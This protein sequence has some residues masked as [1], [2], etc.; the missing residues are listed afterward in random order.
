MK[1]FRWIREVP[2]AK[3]GYE[4]EL[5]DEEK[6]LGDYGK[7]GFR[8]SIGYLIQEGW[9]EEVKDNFW[10]PK[11]GE[12]YFSVYFTGNIIGRR[13]F[14]DE[15]EFQTVV[16]NGNCF[17]TEAEAKNAA[18]MTKELWLSLH[19]PYKNVKYPLIKDIEKKDEKKS[20]CACKEWPQCVH[21]P[22]VLKALWNGY[23]PA[24][25]IIEDVE[26]FKKC[27]Y[28]WCHL[29]PNHLHI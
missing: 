4:F 19:E 27:G 16:K 13:H 29:K 28:D 10:R 17:R 9:I 8:L 23:T 2:F 24:I 5:S 15:V 7:N 26:P 25:Q 21:A 14:C 11:K 12:E 6:V 20:K 3:L 22:E 18:R 1:K